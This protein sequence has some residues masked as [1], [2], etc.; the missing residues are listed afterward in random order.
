MTF[1]M[2]TSRQ[3]CPNHY[4]NVTKQHFRYH[5]E[6]KIYTYNVTSQYKHNGRNKTAYNSASVSGKIIK[7]GALWEAT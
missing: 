2:S 5:S 1:R 4:S 6:K 7:T 3:S